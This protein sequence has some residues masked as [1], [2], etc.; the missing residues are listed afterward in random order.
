M[1]L[2]THTV[3]NRAPGADPVSFFVKMSGGVRH[4]P[5][6]AQLAGKGGE[7][8]VRGTFMID[9]TQVV[10]AKAKAEADEAADVA[11]QTRAVAN[12]KAAV[13]SRVRG[14]AQN[15]AARPQPVKQPAYMAA[16]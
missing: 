13:A 1:L 6:A 2:T 4:L 10:A 7:P 9:M 3:K 16:L 14:A 5:P 11:T 12:H 15:A 8:R